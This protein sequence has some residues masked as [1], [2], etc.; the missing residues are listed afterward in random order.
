ML[1]L[2]FW[3]LRILISKS[4]PTSMA[5]SRTVSRETRL[6]YGLAVSRDLTEKSRKAKNW[7]ILVKFG[8][9]FPKVTN[10]FSP[11]LL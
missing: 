11:I 5:E 2:Q 7:Q 6:R 3:R 4:I 9:I 10:F 8:Q 1:F